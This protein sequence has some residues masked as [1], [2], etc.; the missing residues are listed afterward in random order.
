MAVAAIVVAVAACG[1]TSA[2]TPSPRLPATPGTAAKPLV[3]APAVGVPFTRDFNPFDLTS[4]ASALGIRSLVYEP[5]YEIDALNPQPSGMHPWL[6]TGYAFENGGTELRITVRSDVR[7]SDGAAFGPADVAA[8]FR[9]IRDDPAADYS[10]VPLQSANP[11]VDAAA[12]TVTLHFATAE[13]ASLTEI[14]GDT[15][16]VPASLVTQLGSRLTTGTVSHPVGTGPFMLAGLSTQEM[17]FTPNPHYWGGRPPEPEVDVPYEANTQVVSEAFATGTL[18]WSGAALPDVVCCD[19]PI[20]P[21]TNIIWFPSGSTVTLDFN[22]EPGNDGA[23]GIGDAAVREAVSLGIDRATL[24]AIGE[25]GYEAAA[26]SA[27]GLLPTA[28][29]AYPNPAGANDLPIDSALAPNTGSDSGLEPQGWSG[30]T[31]QRVLEGDGWTPPAGWGS[32]AE[33]KC[34]GSAAADCWTR[35]GQIISFSI[36][37]R[38]AVSDVWADAQLISAELQAA[39][40]DVTTDNASGGAGQ[41]Q[42]AMDAGDFQ[43]AIAS[44]AGGDIPFVQLDSWLDYTTDCTGTPV[45][46]ASGDYGRFDSTAA[47]AALQEYEIAD[48]TTVTGQAA[49]ASAISTLEGIMATQVPDAPLL[50]G[51]DWN[52]HSTVHYAGWP[53]QATPYMDPSPA[54]PQLPY[55]L[56]HLVP[57]P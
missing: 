10:G 35:G 14:L 52:V 21:N 15:Y 32:T 1:G 20:D 27:G 19:D 3:I 8:T 11:T 36:W 18:D 33:A 28:Q 57:A 38:E 55:L 12:H 46:C 41:W 26:S 40:M 37:D 53:S 13:Y 44:G 54:D 51:P 4:T 29:A 22:L 7:L 47:E 50:Y 5:L 31:V 25:S 16:M 45:T 9:A 39:G 34:D 43:A 42:S 49:I 48:P 23:T 2:S 56:M 6:A 17:R 30:P 24:S